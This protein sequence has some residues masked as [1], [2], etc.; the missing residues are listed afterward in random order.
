M[1]DKEIRPLR[2]EVADMKKVLSDLTTT[3]S[4]LRGKC[5]RENVKLMNLHFCNSFILYSF[6]G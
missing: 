6:S 3:V 2:E 1:I 4:G 5:K